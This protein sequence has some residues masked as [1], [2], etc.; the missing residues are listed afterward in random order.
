[1]VSGVAPAAE[2]QSSGRCLWRVWAAQRDERPSPRPRPREREER[3][4]VRGRRRGVV[5]IGGGLI[6]AVAGGWGGL[7]G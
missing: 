5:A 3:G 7:G 1:M 4:R 6:R 2:S